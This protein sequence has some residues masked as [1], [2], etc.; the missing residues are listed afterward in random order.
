MKKSIEL[1][2]LEGLRSDE[3]AARL[4]LAQHLGY[5]GQ[6]DEAEEQ[7]NIL[8]DLSKEVWIE[9][10]SIINNRAIIELLR[11]SDQAAIVNDLK[12]AL[13]LATEDGDRLLI[14]ANLLGAG[15]TSAAA[16]LLRLLE[17]IPDL[18]DELAKIGH[19]NLAVYYADEHDIDASE[20][21]RKI[22]VAM[23]NEPDAG[24][25]NAALG[26]LAPST[27]GVSLRISK[28]YYL[29]FIVH[30]RLTSSTFKT[31]EQ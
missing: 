10:Y 30:W 18:A 23:K 20:H 29:T 16:K 19:H 7:L 12:T 2:E 24:F 28:R 21:H 14:L 4:A 17:E 13:M 8:E 6:L 5:S 27:E 22:A 25:W 3:A 26:N 9:R 1:C 15:Q 11:G 31:V